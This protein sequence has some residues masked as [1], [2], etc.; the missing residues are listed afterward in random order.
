MEKL[1][2]IANDAVGCGIEALFI[3]QDKGPDRKRLWQGRY[4]QHL[5][6]ASQPAFRSR[7][8]EIRNGRRGR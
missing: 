2:D 3:A 4:C 7:P 5:G 6:S 1:I 8:R